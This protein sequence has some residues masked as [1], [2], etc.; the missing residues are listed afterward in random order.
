LSL[1]PF[2]SLDNTPYRPIPLPLSLSDA[3]SM[4]NGLRSNGISSLSNL[5][6]GLRQYY[7]GYHLN[8]GRQLQNT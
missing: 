1:P 6:G 5:L 3:Q 4:I 7:F 2:D 8:V